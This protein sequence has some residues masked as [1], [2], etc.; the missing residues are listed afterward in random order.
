MKNISV[1]G[2]PGK[3][4][5]ECEL[6]RK[7]CGAKGVM[8]VVMDGNKGH[9]FSAAIPSNQVDN[10]PRILRSMADSIEADTKKYREEHT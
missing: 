7:M 5:T 10:V 1:T 9:G 4:D 3:Y 2:T 6:A 8:L